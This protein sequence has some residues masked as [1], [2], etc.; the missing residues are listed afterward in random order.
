MKKL[1][2]LF[3]AG[4]VLIFLAGVSF[5]FSCQNVGKKSTEKAMEEG[6]E[7]STGEDADVDIDN[8]EVTIQQGDATSHLDMGARSWPA[9]A[10][11]EVPEFQYGKIK[12][13][14][15]T[16]TPDL[17]SWNIVYEEVPADAL[18]KYNDELK[19]AGFE[20]V[21]MDMGGQGGSITCEKGDLSLFVMGGGE[22]E[23]A[24]GIGKSR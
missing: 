24:V 23:A 21:F 1:S 15:T 9:D 8:Q 11:D 19:A 18:K 14:N 22:G 20:T 12:A 3:A 4:L 2:S 13:V 16:D 6:I 5:N 10:P 17:Y 7:Q